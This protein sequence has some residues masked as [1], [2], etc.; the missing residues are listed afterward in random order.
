MARTREERG[1][2]ETR[3]AADEVRKTG[4]AAKGARGGI[5]APVKPSP[6]LA[7]VVG[8]DSLP[9]SEVVSKLW[10]YIKSNNLQ[11]PQDKREIVADDRLRSVFGKDSATMFEMNKL[12]AKHLTAT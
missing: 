10:Q 5:T 12:I 6:E 9:R 8:A 11:N 4:K 7:A 1:E 2:Q 3:A